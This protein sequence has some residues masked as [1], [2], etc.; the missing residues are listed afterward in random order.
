ME[1]CLGNLYSP[2]LNSFLNTLTSHGQD[3][4]STSNA[5]YNAPALLLTALNAGRDICGQS[6]SVA[7][8][9]L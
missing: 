5:C 9:K 6:L 3:S 1:L 7:I 4:T 2:F 8:N